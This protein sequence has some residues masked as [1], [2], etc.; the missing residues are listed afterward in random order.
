MAISKETEE[1]IQQLQLLEQSMQSLSI[2]RQSFQI[3]FIETESALK[4]MEKV[5]SGYKIVGNIMI[6][7]NKEDLIKDLKSKR[8]L[9]ELR[10]QNL[11]KQESKIRT[12]ASKLQEEIL[13]KLKAEEG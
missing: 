4:E 13:D 10:I 1:Q 2:Q 5:E 7:S 8:E 11:E 6:L 3:Q 12:K 9:L